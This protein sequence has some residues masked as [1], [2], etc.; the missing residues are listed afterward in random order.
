MS[1]AAPGVRE[2]IKGRVSC[3]LPEL[4]TGSGDWRLYETEAGQASVSAL[5]LMHHRLLGTPRDPELR[6]HWLGR[7]RRL[8][9]VSKP[10]RGVSGCGKPLSDSAG[11][12]EGTARWAFNLGYPRRCWIRRAENEMGQLSH[13]RAEGRK[14][15]GGEGCP[16]VPAPE[17]GMSP[18]S[19]LQAGARRLSCGRL[20]RAL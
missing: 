20:D 19:G 6:R 2:I 13:P 12:G 18:W 14:G 7:H 5:A 17:W 8:L 9:V 16:V 10:P 15:A 3:V 11:S 1:G 4:E